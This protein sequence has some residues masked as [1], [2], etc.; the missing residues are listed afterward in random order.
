MTSH[1]ADFRVTDTNDNAPTFQSTAYSFDVPENVPR[2]S[3][4]GQV[5][6][7]DADADGP[8]SQLSYVLISD[9]ANDVFSLNPSTGV[10]TLT[11][12][13]DYEQVG[14][15]RKIIRC[16]INRIKNVSQRGIWTHRGSDDHDWI[17]KDR[18]QPIEINSRSDQSELKD[19]RI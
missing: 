4:V 12:S 14:I 11:A 15:E 8:N 6:A 7:T 3:R 18:Q 17:R 10:F 9:W 19:A 1:V 16:A 2:G 13:L 5:V